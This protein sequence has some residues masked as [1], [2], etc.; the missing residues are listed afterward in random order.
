[1]TGMLASVNSLEEAELV[2]AG[3]V[4]IIDLKEPNAGSLG[5]LPVETV[6]AIFAAVNGQRPVSATI[7]DL[8]MQPELILSAVKPMAETGVDYIKIG[9]Y[10]N[11]DT[12][13]VIASLSRIAVHQKLIAVVFADTGVDLALIE[14]LKQ[15]GFCGVMLD[16]L[17]KSKGALPAIL[18]L[19]QI[20]QFVKYAHDRQLICGLAGALR[21]PDIP[22]L[23][24][25]KPDYLGFRGALCKQNKRTDRI[26]PWAVRQICKM[27]AEYS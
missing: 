22:L 14:C 16:T 26:D 13:S 20:E 19:H 5:A 25:Y 2:L 8:P 23:L 3:N 12:H 24:P 7:G 6:K 1:M 9:C 27:I 11:G 15:A 18:T 10:P 17:D 21:L 4:D